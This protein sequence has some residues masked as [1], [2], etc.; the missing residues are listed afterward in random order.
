[1]D[2]LQNLSLGYLDGLRKDMSSSDFIVEMKA[3]LEQL[4][5][6]IKSMFPGVEIIKE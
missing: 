2:D 1:M 6:E 3:G 4:E 5:Q